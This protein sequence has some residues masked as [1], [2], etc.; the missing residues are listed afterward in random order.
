MRG[1]TFFVRT[2]ATTIYV[3][4]DVVLPN[5]WWVQHG[6]DKLFDRD[7]STLEKLTARSH[8]NER[9]R[10]SEYNATRPQR[11]TFR[12]RSQNWTES[13]VYTK[14]Q[15]LKFWI[16][17]TKCVS[18]G[19][20]AIPGG[21]SMPDQFAIEPEQATKLHSLAKVSLLSKRRHMA[22]LSDI[23]LIRTDTIWS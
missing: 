2:H 15:M 18:R 16:C 8:R 7:P 3:Y 1:Q 23:W 14:N 9:S 4:I 17:W 6:N 13:D 11:V 20:W 10:R 19:K 21:T 22:L 12:E 5:V